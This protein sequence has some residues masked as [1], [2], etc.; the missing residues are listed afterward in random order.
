MGVEYKEEYTFK[1]NSEFFEMK[2]S[3]D[4]ALKLVQVWQGGAITKDVLDTN[5]VGGKLIADDVDL[6]AMNKEIDDLIPTVN[7]DDE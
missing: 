3:A 2:L 4:D 7:L 1:L 6:E 5:L